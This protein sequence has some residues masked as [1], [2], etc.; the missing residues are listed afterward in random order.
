MVKFAHIA[1]AHIGGW[2]DP[3]LSSL[4]L[5]AFNRALDVCLQENI[6]FVIIAGDLFNTALPGIEYMNSVARRLSDFRR[7]N[8]PVYAIPGSHDFSPSGKTFL[9]TLEEAGLVKLLNKAEVKNNKLVLKPFVDE[10]HNVVLFG[11]PGRRSSLEK[12]YYE[13]LDNSA[14]DGFDDFFKIFVFHSAVLE[15]SS[16]PA[17]SSTAIPLSYLPDGFDYYAAGHVH[18]VIEK[19]LSNKLVVYPGPVF[20]NN[21]AEL[22]SL[23]HGGFYLV[24]FDEHDKS[25]KLSLSYVPIVV[26]NVYSISLNADA[27]TPQDVFAAVKSKIS[28]NEFY[29][30]IVLLRVFGRLR[31]GRVSDID[32]NS[33]VK[34]LY[35]RG[36][37]FVL[38]NT[39]ALTTK[40]TELVKASSSSVEEI[41]K[42]TVKDNLS[43]IT[44]IPDTSKVFYELM[45]LL[46]KEPADGETKSRFELR[47][48][49]EFN[50]LLSSMKISEESNRKI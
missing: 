1:D 42:R 26:K 16:N 35:E 9:S 36:A 22:E 33:L 40:E 24:S 14:F 47:L 21:F 29:D 48:S 32:F 45:S 38:K 19:T 6:D 7:R 5:D 12:S 41:E 2:R 44:F 13:M 43:S 15:L 34:L 4:S 37:Y 8:I 28:D 3:K 30:T 50:Q 31:S 49:S 10:R 46:S 11:M 18:S 23:K 17:Y 25:K 27:L 39:Y 20:P